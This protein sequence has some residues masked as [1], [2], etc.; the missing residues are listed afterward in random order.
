[1]RKVFIS[2]AISGVENWQEHFMNGE[3][4]VLKM[5]DAQ[6]DLIVFNP[7]RFPKPDFNPNDKQDEWQAY[8]RSTITHLMQCNTIYMLK[9]WEKS[10]GA[11]D[12]F[13]MAKEL[14]MEIYYEE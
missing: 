12:E 3:A 9:G 8:M 10:K 5:F 1:M 2:G 14:G 13:Y 6:E 11:F 7:L 4:Q